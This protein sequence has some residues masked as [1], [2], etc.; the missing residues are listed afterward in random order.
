MPKG[1]SDPGESPE[2]TALR[3]VK[4]ETGVDARLIRLIGES[5]YPIEAG[6]KIVH[7]Y[8]MRAAR[9]GAFQPNDEVDAVRWL[10]IDEAGTRL[11]YERERDILSKVNPRAVLSTGTLFLVRHA[12]AGNR[13]EWAGE[14]RMR[15]LSGRGEKQAL[16]LATSLSQAPIERILTSP[17]VRCRQ[18]V[19]PLADKL[20]LEV[21]ERDELS[22]GEGSKGAR[23]LCR[24]LVGSNAVLCSH[25]DVIPSL[26]DWMA[27]QGMT[28]KSEF[29]CKKGS[30][31]EIEVKAGE[32]RK[33]RYLPPPE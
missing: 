12:A 2:T 15:P 11:S 28:L 29:E 32:F 31:W 4:E 5:R 30:A 19:E 17:F 3:E 13:S 22:E 25:G 24:E 27:R 10:T 1:K 33:A 7:W 14:D 23:S 6:E 16:G 26:L 9:A 20:G 21:E 18:T 8:S